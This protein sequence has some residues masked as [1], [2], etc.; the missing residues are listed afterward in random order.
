MPAIQTAT[1]QGYVAIGTGAGT[2]AVRGRALEDM[3]CYLFGLVPGVSI[4]HRNDMNPFNT[5]EIDVAL[6][7]E[8]DAT[9]LHFL[10][11]VVLIESKNW[12]N[13][14]SSIEVN[15]FDTKLRNRGLDFGILVSPH[16]IT[17]DADDLTA[18]HHIV[19]TALKERRRLVVLTTGELLAL[20][21]TD[22]LGHLIKKKLC[23]LAVKGTIS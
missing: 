20:A 12:S 6:W 8:Q 13:P 4:T 22:A 11:N 23:D 17:G 14:V 15:W 1:L 21:D 3:I 5:E 19:A 7:N 10:P 9:G 2:T 18:A 16:G